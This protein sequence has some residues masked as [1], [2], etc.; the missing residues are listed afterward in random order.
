M[1]E[2]PK[3]KRIFLQA[4]SP[5]E[6]ASPISARGPCA[7]S[8]CSSTSCALKIGE[9][10]LTEAGISKCLTE[11]SGC[12]VPMEIYMDIQFTQTGNIYCRDRSYNSEGSS[13]KGRVPAF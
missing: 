11:A 1:S 12:G 6:N 8:A 4:R 13:N 3:Q 9:H 10:S 5:R 2:V 7:F